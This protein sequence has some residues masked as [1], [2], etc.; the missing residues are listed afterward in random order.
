MDTQDTRHYFAPESDEAIIFNKLYLLGFQKEAFL[1]KWKAF[2][3]KEIDSLEDMKIRQSIREVMTFY[4]PITR[5]SYYNIPTWT[6]LYKKGSKFFRV[7]RIESNDIIIPPKETECWRD[8]WNPPEERIADYGR[9]N[10][11]AE[12]LFIHSR[13]KSLHCH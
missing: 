1:D 13:W 12:S 10:Y 3:S 5:Q 11:P 8:F 9:L 6:Y 2:E 4:N 7:R